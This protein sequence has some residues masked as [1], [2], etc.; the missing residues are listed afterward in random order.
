MDKKVRVGH[1]DFEI[2]FTDE[3]II[4]EKGI[5][6]WGKVD[7]VENKIFIYNG[8]NKQLKQSTLI[9]EILHCIFSQCGFDGDK[10]E[11]NIIRRLEPVL[12]EF[13]LEN[14]IK[15]ELEDIEP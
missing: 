15:K 13:I 3:K 2:I 11:E 6:L 9:H 14:D 1:Y 12:T 10:K 4:D 5:E 7:W 8:L